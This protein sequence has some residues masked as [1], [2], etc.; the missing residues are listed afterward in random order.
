MRWKVSCLWCRKCVD[1]S[2]QELVQMLAHSINTK[3]K[4]EATSLTVSHEATIT[5]EV[6]EAKQQCDIMTAVISN[7]FVQMDI[8]QS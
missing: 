4:D 6:I 5:T 1:I 3:L 7:A 2:N 8:D